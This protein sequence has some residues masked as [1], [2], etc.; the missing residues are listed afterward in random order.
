MTMT[1]IFHRRLVGIG[2]RWLPLESSRERRP[3]SLASWLALAGAGD[4]GERRTGVVL[5]ADDIAGLDL[6]RIVAAPLI[7]LT[8]VKFTDGRPYSVARLLRDRFGFAGE[9][10]AAGDVLLDQIPLLLRCGFDSFE[11]EHAPTAEALLHGHLPAL[12]AAYQQAARLDVPLRPTLAR[13]A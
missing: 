10:R 13:S 12:S 11:V 6:E 4:G 9:I 3:V 8:L 7:V 1:Q 5:V 2:G